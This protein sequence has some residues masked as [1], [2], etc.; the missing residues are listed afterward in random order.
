MSKIYLIT[1]GAGFIGSH[2][3]EALLANGAKVRVLDNLSTGKKENIPEGAEFIKGSITDLNILQKAC[4]GIYGI[5]HAAALPRVQFSIEYPLETNEVN[6]TGTLNVLMAARDCGV[7]RVVYSASSSAYGDQTTLPLMETMKPNPKSPYG[8]QKYVGEHYMNLAAMFW[9]L[10]TAS[11]RYFN[12]YGPRM[13][14]EGAYVTVI[15]VFLQQRGRDE[16]LTITGDGTQ[17]R[18]FTFVSDVVDANMRAMESAKVGHGEIINIGA[19]ENHSV[20]Q[21]AAAIG[22]PTKNIPPR[23]EPHDTLADITLAKNLL[24]WEPK[25]KFADGLEL[26]KHWF[27]SLKMRPHTSLKRYET[28]AR[29]KRRNRA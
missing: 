9:G 15:S 17:T 1:G 8:L 28:S 10:E 2:I 27:N 3:A 22:G 25:V 14:S 5:F 24:G 18:D 6:V 29:T 16:T 7:K 19:H 26:T 11:L 13:A 21:V 4:K 12:V 20:N 23:I